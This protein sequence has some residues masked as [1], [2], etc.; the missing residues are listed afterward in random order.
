M[1]SAHIALGSHRE[2]GTEPAPVLEH[3]V[4]APDGKESVDY[5]QPLVHDAVIR[6]DLS[7]GVFLDCAVLWVGLRSAFA[8]DRGASMVPGSASPA[9]SVGGLRK[10]RWASLVPGSAS[11]AR[12]VG[13]LRKERWASFASSSA[14]STWCLIASMSPNA[15]LVAPQM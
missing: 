10:E 6:A 9:R 12:S 15:P 13:G 1:R 4:D 5:E 3:I 14:G 8:H 11:P 2:A 7:A